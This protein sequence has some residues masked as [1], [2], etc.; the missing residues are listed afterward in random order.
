MIKAILAARLKHGKYKN[1]NP[2]L[3]VQ[4][5]MVEG[6]NLNYRPN[7]FEWFANISHTDMNH[8]SKARFNSFSNHISFI[9]ITVLY[10]S[11]MGTRFKKNSGFQNGVFWGPRGS[12]IFYIFNLK[13]NCVLRTLKNS[14]AIFWA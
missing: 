5:K 13:G 12:Y 2:L 14:F 10:F 4:M 3:P 11:R 8:I 1:L 7:W 6:R 9:I